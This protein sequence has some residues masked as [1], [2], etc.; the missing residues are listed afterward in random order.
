MEV[1]G[2]DGA[3]GALEI[4]EGASVGVYA[5]VFEDNYSDSGA[6][7]RMIG[8]E[9]ILY[10]ERTRFRGGFAENNGGA[11][12]G[13]GTVN[14]QTSDFIG[15]RAGG[16][17]G[18]LHMDGT[19][20]VLSDVGFFSNTARSAGA[21]SID[22]LGGPTHTAEIDKI[23]ACGNSAEED[24]GALSLIGSNIVL[25]SSVFLE[26]HAPR[27]G[28]IGF[29]HP[30]TSMRHLTLAGNSVEGPAI[31]R[32][33]PAGPSGDTLIA[34]SLF[35]GDHVEVSWDAV[36][37]YQP[38]LGISGWD[39]AWETQVVSGVEGDAPFSIPEEIPQIEHVTGVCWD[40]AIDCGGLADALTRDPLGRPLLE[41]L[42]TLVPLADSPLFFE[43]DLG[44]RQIGAFG[45]LQS[46]DDADMDGWPRIVD[47]DD[48]PSGEGASVGPLPAD[49]Q[50]L[51][52]SDTSEQPDTG[53]PADTES[54]TPSPGGEPSTWVG[55]R[56]C[57]C[58]S[59]AGAGAWLFLPAWLLLR[60]RARSRSAG[61]ARRGH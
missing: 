16:R 29:G 49:C 5:S 48:D 53:T 6:H 38:K 52:P 44:E 22:L 19:E 23:V 54:T 9:S 43:T 18:A 4:T 31:A 27:G 3:S 36:S 59:G 45:G 58:A 55:H 28:A 35:L 30:I 51:G 39:G 56:V 1:R 57:S 17:G 61:V 47:A 14:I 12:A 2:Q 34:F 50:L 11:I 8:D 32:L 37:E 46:W 24:S 15:N 20:L 25:Q 26:N 40:N 42:S 33:D 21:A 10:V 60:R 13:R 7:I 41:A